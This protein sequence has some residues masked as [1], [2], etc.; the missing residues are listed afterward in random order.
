M[1]SDDQQLLSKA[2]FPV[3]LK[4]YWDESLN[5]FLTRIAF[6]NARESAVKV[7]K[8]ADSKALCLSELHRLGVGAA[9]LADMCDLNVEEIERRRHI[10][11]GS[12]FAPVRLSAGEIAPH[13]VTPSKLRFAPSTYRA[14][15]YHRYCWDFGFLEFDPDTGERLLDQCPHCQTEFSWS[16]PSFFNCI[17]CGKSIETCQQ[18]YVCEDTRTIGGIFADLLSLDPGKQSIARSQLSIQVRDLSVQQLFHFLFEISDLFEFKKPTKKD[19]P[20]RLEWTQIL[21]RAFQIATEWPEAM[22]TV[23]DEA[24]ASATERT[25]RFGLAK[26]FG[27]LAP[28]LREWDSVAEIRAVI[29]PVVKMYLDCNPEI[30]LKQSSKVAEGIDVD[31]RFVSL[32]EIQFRY[33][34]SHR[35]AHRLL[36]IPGVVV[37]GASGSGAPLRVDQYKVQEIH[38]TLS[39]LISK[40]AIRNLW[41]IPHDAVSQLAEADIFCTVTE[42]VVTLVENA[43]GLYRR[44]Q[45]AD[46]VDRL[47]KCTDGSDYDGLTVSFRGIVAELKDALASPWAAVADAILKGDLKPIKISQKRTALFGKIRFRKADVD[48]WV[49]LVARS[50]TNTFSVEEAG[51]R[52]QIHKADMSHFITTGMIKALE[53]KAGERGRRISILE[54]LKFEQS[55]VSAA[56]IAKFKKTSTKLVVETLD[57]MGIKS[58]SGL[59][60]GRRIYRT[61]DIPRDFRVFTQME[62]NERK[63]A[64][65]IKVKPHPWRSASFWRKR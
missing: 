47:Q 15:Q 60:A 18:D 10:S 36:Q 27:E 31:D 21:K 59:P 49:S 1:R 25:G 46:V 26:E 54:L 34:W 62:I 12:P 52:L 16:K 44:K 58:L 9:A 65:G 40:R 39:E 8:T 43:D 38:E 14:I 57:V 51:A 61:V 53:P 30:A 55:F 42:P 37:G 63:H 50:G 35:K 20:L 11:A 48:E 33:G 56:S 3:K 24:R 2:G 64:S 6:E 17:A 32:K 28:L 7:L 29:L 5:G 41:N 13:L 4:P 23:L 45:V 22:L 19:R